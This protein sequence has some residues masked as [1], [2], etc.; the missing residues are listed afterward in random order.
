MYMI[1][2]T[3]RSIQSDRPVPK[4]KTK[5]EQKVGYISVGEREIHT[6]LETCGCFLAVT[7]TLIDHAVI[8]SEARKKR[9]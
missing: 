4:R 6:V 1:G 7:A 5:L 9:T 3:G 2:K 8:A